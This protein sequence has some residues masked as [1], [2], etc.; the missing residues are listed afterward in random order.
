MNGLRSLQENKSLR[1]AS[2]DI[3]T[4]TILLL[5]AEV[6]DGKIIPLYN[7]QVI[8]RLGKN[9]DATGFIQK[10]AF[11]KVLKALSEFKTIAE[12][13]KVDKIIAIG[14][15]ALRDARNK[16]EF[17]DFIAQ[18]TGIKIKVISG[19]EE[20][21][22]TYLGAVSGIEPRFLSSKITVIDIGGGSTEIINGHG[23]EIKKFISLD[24]GTVRI[25][26]KF[27]KHSPPFEEEINE[28][29]NFITQ[30]FQKIEPDFDFK[31]SVLVGVA[32]TVTTLSAYDLKL[33]IYDGE[34]VNM[35]EMTFETIEKIYETFKKLSSDEIGKIP[36]ISKGREDVIFAGI[37]I[38]REFMKKFNFNR[39]ITSD[40]GVRYGV[41]LDLLQRNYL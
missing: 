20:A 38:L 23:F 3:G 31:N 29:R 8:A 16:V 28:A 33:E 15:S 13:F 41:I 39:I 5:I 4:N 12:N 21:R 30:E 37:L 24:I 22:L 14:T 27:L 25:T 19:E 35:H 2:I 11:E 36:Q 17:I 34:K 1:I 7:A 40:R 6:I 26:E 32:A 9:V 10:E 18:E